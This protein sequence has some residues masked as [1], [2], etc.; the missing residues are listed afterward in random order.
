MVAVDAVYRSG[1]FAARPSE[2]VFV[3]AVTQAE[4]MLGARLL[5]SGRRRVV[6]EGAL[7]VMF[8]EDFAGRVLPF[9]S[10]AVKAYARRGRTP[11]RRPS[12]ARPNLDDDRG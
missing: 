9:D 3:T 2:S 6:L 10:T 8:A 12:R 7:S 4:M 11:A 1:W 5:P